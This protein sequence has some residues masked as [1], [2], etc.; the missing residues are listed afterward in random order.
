[1]A[2]KRTLIVSAMIGLFGAGYALGRIDMVEDAQAAELADVIADLQSANRV[3][4]LRTYTAPEGKL[5][6]LQA[7]FRDHTI[8]IFQRHGMV[9]VGYWLPQDSALRQNTLV[10][11]LA[12]PSRAAADRAWQEFSADPEWQR[13]SEESQRDGRIV[14]QVQRMYLDP[15]DFSP[16]K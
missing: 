6:A 15:T 10:Y 16:M 11:L 9:S 2:A 7:R 5:D 14:T 12:H 3:F 4:E 1:M 8:R 13:V